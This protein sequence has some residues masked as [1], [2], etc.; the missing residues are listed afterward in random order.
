MQ[1]NQT[2]PCYP[3]MPV[4]LPQVRYLQCK[5]AQ[6]MLGSFIHT[7]TWTWT[8]NIHPRAHTIMI[9]E[10]TIKDL[11]CTAKLSIAQWKY[12]A[13]QFSASF[14]NCAQHLANGE[15][16]L[17]MRWWLGDCGQLRTVRLGLLLFVYIFIGRLSRWEIMLFSNIIL[18][19]NMLHVVHVC[20]AFR[21][22]CF[23]LVK[24]ISR[25]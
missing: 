15:I 3:H 19:F 23:N 5:I 11:I 14:F 7:W 4:D 10:L 17:L 18:W 24:L 6:H 21:I 1:A 25:F 9:A 12:C 20:R 13:E 2:N 22:V 8:M 16:M